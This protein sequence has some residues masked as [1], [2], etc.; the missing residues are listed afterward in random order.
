MSD[1]ADRWRVTKPWQRAVRAELARRGWGQ[2]ELAQVIRERPQVVSHAMNGAKSTTIRGAVDAALGLP[3]AK[4]KRR[5]KPRP[6][7]QL[8]GPK[9]LAMSVMR[10]LSKEELCDVIEWAIDLHGAMP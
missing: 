3:A 8:P 7:P 5:R 10:G 9:E 4:P 6:T 1:K 2:R